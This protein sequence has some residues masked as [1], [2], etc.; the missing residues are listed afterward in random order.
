MPPGPDRLGGETGKRVPR[1]VT[2][3][4]VG[5]RTEN[6]LAEAAVEAGALLTVIVSAPGLAEQSLRTTLESFPSVQVVGTAAGCLSALQ[7]VRERQAGLVVIDANVPFEE[8]QHF[9]RLVEQEGQ[10][11]RCLVLTETTGQVYRALAAGADAAL[12]WDA[13][14]Q[15]LGAALAGLQRP[16]AGDAQRSE[17]DLPEGP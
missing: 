13:S 5:P 4:P 14:P 6:S 8:V 2:S 17:P 12:R 1:M 10:E 3:E 9:L 11:T 7:M 16:R 15:E